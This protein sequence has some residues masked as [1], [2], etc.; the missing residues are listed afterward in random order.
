MF[1][2]IGLMPVKLQIEF[3]LQ[4][5]KAVH[6]TPCI[7]NTNDMFISQYST[8]FMYF[9]L[10]YKFLGQF[11][12]AGPHSVRAPLQELQRASYV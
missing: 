5:V 2:M 12:I 1:T 3:K 6:L 11:L 10:K 9:V 8:T 4:M 7:L